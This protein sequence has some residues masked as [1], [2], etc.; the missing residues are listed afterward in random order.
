MRDGP[1]NTILLAEISNSDI[2]W[3]EPRDLRADEMSFTINDPTRPSISSPH[4]RGPAVVFADSIRAY[5]IDRSL[6]PETLKAL[7]TIAGGEP[8][9]KWRLVRQNP[10]LG[11]SMLAE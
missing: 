8:V 10:R 6:R 3:M 11:G 4:S 9:L 5:R 2:H 1:E 7:T